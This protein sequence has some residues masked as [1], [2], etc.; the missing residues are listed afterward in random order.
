[1]VRAADAIRAAATRYLRHFE[2]GATGLIETYRHDDADCILIT[3]GSVAGTVRAAV[4][5]LRA[6]GHRVGMVR[7]RYLRPFPV[8]E[9]ATALF[10]RT[11]TAPVRA[12]GVLE[13]DI[14]FGHQGSVSLEVKSA[15]YEHASQRGAAC[16]PVINFIAGLGGQD[17][18]VHHVEAFFADLAERANHPESVGRHLRAPGAT[19]VRFA[20]M[21]S[22][23]EENQHQDTTR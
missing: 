7:L 9:L 2:R 20:G 19:D 18:G 21:E 15:L 4:D 12:I 10:A 6:Q 23:L 3:L 5:A 17:V 14:S 8:E 16:V 13:K 22:F 1:M 11:R